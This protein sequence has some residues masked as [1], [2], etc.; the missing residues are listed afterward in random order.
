MKPAKPF[1][2]YYDGRD[3]RSCSPFGTMPFLYYK[4][5]RKSLI[6]RWLFRRIEKNWEL[7][8]QKIHLSLSEAMAS[9]ELENHFGKLPFE[10]RMNKSGGWIADDVMFELHFFHPDGKYEFPIWVA[11][12]NKLNVIH[13][14]PSW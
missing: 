9:R 1:N 7:Y 8:W 2:E 12:F 4:W 13:T 6:H 11:A 14:Q 5:V 10:I 3:M